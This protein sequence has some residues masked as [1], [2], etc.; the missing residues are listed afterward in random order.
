MAIGIVGI[1][2]AL[3]CV[4]LFEKAVTFAVKAVFVLVALVALA[5]GVGVLT[6]KIDVPAGIIDGR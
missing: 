3:L 5:V 2:V 4:W 6:G 1:V